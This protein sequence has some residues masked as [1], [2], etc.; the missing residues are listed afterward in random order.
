LLNLEARWIAR[1]HR[2]PMGTSLLVI[3]RRPR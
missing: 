1:G 2:L 3:A